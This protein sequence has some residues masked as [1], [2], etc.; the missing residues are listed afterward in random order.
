MK[1]INVYSSFAGQG[2]TFKM[3]VDALKLSSTGKR[4]AF[5]TTESNSRVIIKKSNQI[6]K[7]FGW[8]GKINR[9]NFVVFFIPYGEHDLFIRK[10]EYIKE[11]FDYVFID[12]LEGVLKHINTETPIFKKSQELFIKLNEIL[13]SEGSILEK[14]GTT[15]SCYRQLGEGPNHVVFRGQENIPDEI[16]DVIVHKNHCKKENFYVI[17]FDFE[18]GTIIQYDLFTILN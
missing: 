2:K 11:E 10:M 15:S 9:G 5:I 7:Y 17:S 1:K 12:T 8:K 3:L 6:S 4:V 14:I 18:D 13:N 16:K